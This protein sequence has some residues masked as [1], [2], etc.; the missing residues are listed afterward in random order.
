M[1]IKTNFFYFIIY[2]QCG[3]Y[4]PVIKTGFL[5]KDIIL[6]GF[7]ILLFII[8]V[9][10]ISIFP[11]DDYISNTGKNNVYNL[12]VSIN[13]IGFITGLLLSTIIS[14]IILREFEL[15]IYIVILLLILSISSIIVYF[16]GQINTFDKNWITYLFLFLPLSGSLY[17]ISKY[18]F[19]LLITNLFF[20]DNSYSIGYDS[21]SSNNSSSIEFE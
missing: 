12:Y 11:Y 4:K 8:Y 6:I 7:T 15:N 14:D 16:V 19:T 3:F 5:K 18:T 13:I 2:M 21:S 1:Q 17:F 20:V 10:L 9:V